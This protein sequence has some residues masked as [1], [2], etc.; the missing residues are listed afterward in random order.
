[1][2]TENIY[3]YRGAGPK[4]YYFTIHSNR[5]LNLLSQL[6]EIFRRLNA[7]LL[8][9]D[10]EIKH[11]VNVKF[12]VSD[13][14]N[15]NQLILKH[16]IYK[17]LKN[18][19]AL[20][21]IEQIPADGSK[22]N[23]LFYAVKRDDANKEFADG[24][25]IYKTPNYDHYFHSGMRYNKEGSSIEVQVDNIFTNFIDSISIKS[26]MSVKDNCIRT[27]L[28]IRDIDKTY[29]KVVESRKSIFHQYGL[30]KDTNYIAST[31][32]EGKSDNPIEDVSIDFYS[33]SK[34]KKEQVKFLKAPKYLNSTIDYGV[35]FE[36]G[37]CVQYGDRE[38]I[39]ISGTASIDN[40]GE[41]VHVGDAAMQMK[42]AIINIEELLND[43][44]TNL[45]SIA[46]LIVYIRDYSDYNCVKD[47]MNEQFKE[48][49][50]VIVFAKVCR[51]GWLI[52]IECVAITQ[53]N[54][55]G[56]LSF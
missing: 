17:E 33:V 11:L 53:Q 55:R 54:R 1:M 38:H 32:I 21:I 52:E 26:N 37:T 18:E 8:K 23:M 6:D 56:L 42:R 5:N 4:E 28:Y 22:I 39:F 46:Y 9:Y 2:G 43:A 40:R 44:D 15:Q 31:G 35:T 50:N 49:P 29:T 30:T 24:M 51:P 13:Y 3:N 19:V 10:L 48:V 47:I 45:S 12:F 20:S 41:I 14:I 7:L 16:P 25:L 36:R 34:I 27:W